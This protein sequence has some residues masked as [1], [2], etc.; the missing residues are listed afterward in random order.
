MRVVQIF[1]SSSWTIV[2]CTNYKDSSENL[3][4][5]RRLSNPVLTY[6]IIIIAIRIYT[7]TDGT[8]P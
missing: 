4:Y 7:L 3:F 8:V 2:T 6:N 1:N 5:T